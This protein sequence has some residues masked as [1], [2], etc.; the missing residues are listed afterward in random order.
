[1][2]TKRNPVRKPKMVPI[3]AMEAVSVN[4]VLVSAFGALE[5]ANQNLAEIAHRAL[6]PPP[7]KALDRLLEAMPNLVALYLTE[8]QRSRK[9]FDRTLDKSAAAVPPNLSVDTLASLVQSL[10]SEQRIAM[11]TVCSEVQKPTMVAIF[12]AFPPSDG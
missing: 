11:L 1:M 5:K 2:K 9:A 12:N 10:T 3:E 4:D 6:V 8:Q 7:N